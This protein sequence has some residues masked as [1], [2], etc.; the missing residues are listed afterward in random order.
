MN[1]IIKFASHESGVGERRERKMMVESEP[2]AMCVCRNMQK[3]IIK[4][5]V[6]NNTLA[7]LSS[8]QSEVYRVQLIVEKQQLTLMNM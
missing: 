3:Y 4:F 8:M 7:A 1:D 5:N 6:D 2:A